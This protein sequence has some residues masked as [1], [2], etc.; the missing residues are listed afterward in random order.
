MAFRKVISLILIVMMTLTILAPVHANENVKNEHPEK[1]S[2]W[3]GRPAI[4]L[5]ECWG[6][7]DASTLIEGGG[8]YLIYSKGRKVGVVDDG[9]Y[10]SLSR[11]QG[12]VLLGDLQFKT[13]RHNRIESFR[14]LNDE[15]AVSKA[16]LFWTGFT[17]G[18]VATLALTAIIL[19]AAF[20][21]VGV[22]P[23]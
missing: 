7:P 17:V 1:P 3:V 14:Y 6:S 2:S 4:D 19:A 8:S 5:F 22:Y 9:P 21:T 15:P 12:L 18:L 13:D 10:D 16:G 23:T 11:K 20:S